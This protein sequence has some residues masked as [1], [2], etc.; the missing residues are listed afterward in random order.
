MSFGLL[1]MPSRGGTGWV[2]FSRT[3]KQSEAERWGLSFGRPAVI[4]GSHCF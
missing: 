2:N 1:L 4:F 3:L